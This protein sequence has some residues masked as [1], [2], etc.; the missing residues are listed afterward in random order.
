MNSS[1]VAGPV[2]WWRVAAVGRNPRVTI[3]RLVVLVVLTFLAFRYVFV[4]VRVTG[5]SMTPFYKDGERRWISPALTSVS[6]LARGDV[7]AIQTSGRHVMYL[8][9]ILGLPGE[10]IRIA[11]GDVYING[12]L[13]E[14]PYIL[15]RSPSWNWPTNGGERL[16]GPEEFFVVGDNRA[17][18]LENHYFG[19]ADRKRILGKVIR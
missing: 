2:P 7:V 15:N 13:I 8:K 14:E 3:V 4:P 11:K 16:L 1:D 9:R 18:P 17:M 12:E 6:G 5:I 10:K 19:V